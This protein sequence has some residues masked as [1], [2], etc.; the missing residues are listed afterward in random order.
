MRKI[1]RILEQQVTRK[2]FLTTVAL[3]FIGLFGFSTII[4][5]FTK[6]EK[7]VNEKLPEYGMGA[8]GP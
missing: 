3:A 2:E 6:D 7:P 8:Y 1:D 4:G 5:L